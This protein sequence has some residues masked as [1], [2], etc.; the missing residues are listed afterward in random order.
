[1]R[2][3]TKGKFVI[4][5]SRKTLINISAIVWI[6]GGIVL[7][8]KGISLIK[9]AQIIYPSI[10]VISII[11]IV[12]LLVG[13]IKGKFLMG[14]F[15][16][17]NIKRINNIVEPKIHQFFEPKFILFLILMIL[18]GITLSNL[19]VGNYGFLLAVGCLDFA[20]STALLSSTSVFLNKKETE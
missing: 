7:L 6:L 13:L 20:L 19:A 5:T 17:N 1:L 8:L 14:K 10:I 4:N 11:I 15:C 2:L 16:K 18:T 3:N 9:A 12:A